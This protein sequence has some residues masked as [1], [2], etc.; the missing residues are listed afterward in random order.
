[1]ILSNN[2]YLTNI[3]IATPIIF[4]FA[5]QSLVQIIDSIMVGRLGAQ[6]LAAVS[7]STAIITNVMMFGIGISIALTPFIGD[8]WSKGK[9]K[10]ASDYFTNSFIINLIAGTIISIALIYLFP[11]INYLNQPQE[12]LD[13]T[14]NYYLLV[15]ISIVP[16]M[17]FL[18]FKQFLEGVGNTKISMIITLL[19]NAFNVILNYILIYGKLGFSPMGI[20]GAG[21]ATLISRIMM[22][23]LFYFAITKHS[24]YKKYLYFI[25]LK[26]LSIKKQ[27]EL[28]KIG[29]PIS[30]QML[31]EF[32]SLS[33]ITLMMGWFGA[34]AL[35]AN[36]IIQTTIGFSFMISNGV[37]AAATIL[38]SHQFGLG[39][40][41]EVKKNGFA[42]IHISVIIMAI[43]SIIFLFF[44]TEIASIFTSDKEVILI[45]RNIFL[46]VVF[47][48]I[49]DGIQVTTLGALR[50]IKDVNI[51]SFYAFTCYILIAIPFA[52]FLGVKLSFN[53]AG[54]FAGFGIG[55]LCASILFTKRFILKT[56]KIKEK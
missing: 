55:L 13:I 38:V 14:Y 45:A 44:G 5:G 40:I 8:A 33:V 35:A 16:F 32:T 46:V 36:Q 53:E 15:S 27:L 3:R 51:V 48:E 30:G 42:A 12:V 28:I 18:A 41:E 29:L 21:V 50:G 22:P 43:A 25:Q 9:H 7:L 37:A 47:F 31:L 4:S 6:P 17:T 2:Y 56:Q 26:S 19:A 24:K 34:K 10:I 39:K 20:D 11:F 52:Y 54:L 49:F 23:L 1:M